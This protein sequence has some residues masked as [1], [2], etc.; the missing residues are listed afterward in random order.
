MTLQV[1]VR[2]RSPTTRAPH[3]AG[4]G[5]R[6][7]PAPGTL[8]AVVSHG[9][10]AL[11]QPGG[12][13]GHKGHQ[14]GPAT[15]RDRPQPVITPVAKASPVRACTVPGADAEAARG[16]QDADDAARRRTARSIC[17]PGTS[18][19]PPSIGQVAQASAYCTTRSVTARCAPATLTPMEPAADRILEQLSELVGPVEYDANDLFPASRRTRFASSPGNA[20]ADRGVLPVAPRHGPR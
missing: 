20:N 2:A 18:T 5:D 8:R 4:A 3:N 17:R 6:A 1:G 11:A 15:G 12:S 19:S 16:L 13:P 7:P 14:P 9:R 10:A